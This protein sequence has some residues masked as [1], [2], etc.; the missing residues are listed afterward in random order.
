MPDQDGS[1][2]LAVNDGNIMTSTANVTHE[3]KAQ[4]ESIVTG[5]VNS[6]RDINKSEWGSSDNMAES[7]DDMGKMKTKRLRIANKNSSSDESSS[8]D[9]SGSVNSTRDIN[10]SEQGSSDNM[11]ESSDDKGKM[12][13]KRWRI[14]NKKIKP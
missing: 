9:D 10:K 2:N 14:A 13:T 7:S 8:S 6:T 11:T 12:K 5:G 3:A 1:N 4:E